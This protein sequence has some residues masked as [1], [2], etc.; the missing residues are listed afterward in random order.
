LNLS[1]A[2]VRQALFDLRR[3]YVL[4]FRAAIAPTVRNLLGEVDSEASELLDLLPEAIALENGQPGTDGEQPVMARD[5][6][7]VASDSRQFPIVGNA[8]EPLP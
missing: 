2:A 7:S 6:T 5:A 3:N 4:Q 8:G 1:P